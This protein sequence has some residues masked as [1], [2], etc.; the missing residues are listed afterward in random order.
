[1]KR[2]EVTESA[3]SPSYHSAD[4]DLDSDPMEIT[5]NPDIF[6]ECVDQYA[7]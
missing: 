7:N 1:M 6:I 4:S 5:S 3:G 2:D